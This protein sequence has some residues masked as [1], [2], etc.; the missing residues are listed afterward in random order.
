MQSDYERMIIILR[1]LPSRYERCIKFLFWY[2]MAWSKERPL[3]IKIRILYIFRIGRKGTEEWL[4]SVHNHFAKKSGDFFKNCSILWLQNV[5]GNGVSN[6]K[7]R[8]LF[9][10]NIVIAFSFRW[11]SQRS[12]VNGQRTMGKLAAGAA[13]WPRCFATLWRLLTRST[14]YS[15]RSTV[16][17]KM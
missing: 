17:G 10:S 16:D 13:R 3:C 15:Q 6:E 4:S 12:T 5:K 11:R 2:T 9:C 1:F 7:L 14:V 8:C